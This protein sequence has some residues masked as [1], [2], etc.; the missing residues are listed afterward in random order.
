VPALSS[1]MT[2]ALFDEKLTLAQILGLGLAV[3]GVSI[4]SRG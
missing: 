2:Y 1:L 3:I 4:A